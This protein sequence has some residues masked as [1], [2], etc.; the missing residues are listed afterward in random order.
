MIN[1]E[2]ILI[3]PLFI[4]P[5]AK[6]GPCELSADL[7]EKF[8]TFELEPNEENSVSKNKFILTPK[9]NIWWDDEFDDLHLFIW[10]SLKSYMKDIIL[11]DPGKET[12]I[13]ITQSWLNVCKPKQSHHLHDHPNSFLSWSLNLSDKPIQLDFLIPAPRF[14]LVP[15]IKSYNSYNA[16]TQSIVYEPGTLVI[17]PSTLKHFVKANAEQTARISLSGNTMIS[18]DLGSEQFLTHAS[19]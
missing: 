9:K 18:G 19:I 10:K 6:F 15:P 2:K 7:K 5:V 12:F 8:T 3:Y 13:E 4:V 11:V 16:E 14:W 1:K 17:F